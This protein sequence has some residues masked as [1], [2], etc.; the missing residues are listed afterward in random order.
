MSLPYRKAENPVEGAALVRLTFS[1]RG[2][3]D[4]PNFKAIYRGVLKDLGVTDD[5][6]QAY[7]SRHKDR[8]VEK[9]RELGPQT[10]STR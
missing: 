5:E 7:I 6:V 1:A 4:E 3:L 10:F 8:L 9:L 2:E